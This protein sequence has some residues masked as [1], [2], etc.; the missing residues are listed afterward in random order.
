MEKK[1]IYIFLDVDGVLNNEASA[2]LSSK[3]IN[4]LSAENIMRLRDLIN[5]IQARYI[6]IIVISSSWRY[7][8]NGVNVLKKHLA[9][10]NLHIDDILDLKRLSCR[11]EEIKSYCQNHG[12]SSDSVLILDDDSDMGDMAERHIKTYV[13]DGLTYKEIEQSLILIG[14]RDEVWKP[15]RYG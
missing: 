6:P 5:I 10:Y 2:K 8:S 12:I 1:Q 7:T 13:R 9:Q 15:E 3:K 4:D 14:L 11:G